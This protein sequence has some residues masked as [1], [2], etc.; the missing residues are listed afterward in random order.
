MEAR[1]EFNLLRHFES[2][3]IQA[4]GVVVADVAQRFSHWTAVKSLDQWCKQQGVP[5]V[6]GVDTRAIVTL[7]REQ[8]STLAKITV[9]EDYDAD[10]DEAYQDTGSINLVKHVSTKAPFH[11][12][13]SGD[14]QI[15]LVDCG[16]KEG[17]LRS[18]TQRG[19]SITV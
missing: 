19:A 17:I 14:L 11:V 7:L 3:Y 9:G 16:V 8:G 15:A 6:T 4:A 2:E 5:A 13:S 1:D 12:P 10:Q 18:L